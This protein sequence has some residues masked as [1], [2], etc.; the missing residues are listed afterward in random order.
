MIYLVVLWSLAILG[1]LHKVFFLERWER[2]S[3]GLYL[4]MGWMVVFV[5][6]D[7]LPVVHFEVLK[8]I[9]IGGFFYTIGVIFF[10]RE[11]MPYNHAVWHVCVLGGSAAHYIALWK[12]FQV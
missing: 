4:F 9:A 8:W 3:L 1:T 5:L 11:A 10:I 7:L 12:V 2:F 6:P